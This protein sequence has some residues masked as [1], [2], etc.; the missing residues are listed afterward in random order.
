MEWAIVTFG[1]K[2]CCVAASTMGG[3]ANVLTKR[4]WGWGAV[5]DI[6]LSIVV[7]WLA[8]EFLIPAAMAHWKFSAESAVGLA[9]LIGYCGIRLLPKLEEAMIKKVSK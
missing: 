4:T 9:F 7:G 5:K 2:L 8:A 1:G 3:L 6:G